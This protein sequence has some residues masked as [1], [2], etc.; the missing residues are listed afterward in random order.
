MKYLLSFT[1]TALIAVIAALALPL[2]PIQ[3]QEMEIIEP[4]A[5]DIGGYALAVQE[6][7]YRGYVDSVDSTTNEYGATTLTFSV[8]LRNGELKDQTIEIETTIPA[9]NATDRFQQG[10]RIVVVENQGP[11]GTLYFIADHYRV[12]WFIA[13]FIVFLAAA[14]AFA[15]KQAFFALGGLT[16]S[17]IV[18]AAYIIPQI[19]AGKNPV[20]VGLAG[21]IAIS[22]ASLYVAHGWHKRTSVALAGMLITIVIATVLAWVTNSLAHMIGIGS[23][24]AYNLQIT[25]ADTIDLRGLFL[26]GVI[27][28]ALGVLDDITTS[29]AATVEELKKANPAFNRKELYTRAI[30]VGREHIAS[31]INTLV[32]AYAGASLPLLLL[33]SLDSQPLWVTLNSQF[34]GEEL[35]RTLVG[36]IALIL[37]VPITTSIAAR[38]F[39]HEESEKGE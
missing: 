2:A 12:H 20:I 38:V 13:L 36:S 9:G 6:T 18:L 17:I 5:E 33:I 25:F 4:G 19:G 29:I 27:I 3:A 28:G 23:E 26:V 14:F 34:L 10:D 15:R 21:A 16:L 35:V 39:E 32:L 22:V 24:E 8:E 7:Y 31:L 37:A 30:R 11:N 1:A